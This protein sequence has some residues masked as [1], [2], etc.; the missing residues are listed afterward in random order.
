MLPA[1]PHYAATIT[2]G[3]GVNADQRLFD[4][5]TGLDL[6]TARPLGLRLV[7][8]FSQL[9]MNLLM[10]YTGRVVNGV[11]GFLVTA[12]TLTGMIIWWPGIA[13]WRDSLTVRWDTNL[14]RLNW[15]LHSAIGFWTSAIVL[16]W[17]VTGAYLVFPRPFNFII[18]SLGGRAISLGQIPHSIHVGDFGGWPVKAFGSRLAWCPPRFSSPASSC[19]GSAWCSRSFECKSAARRQRRRIFPS[20]S[21]SSKPTAS[22]NPKLRAQLSAPDR[23]LTVHL[24]RHA[25]CY[26]AGSSGVVVSEGLSAFSLASDSSTRFLKSPWSLCESPLYIDTTLISHLAPIGSKRPDFCPG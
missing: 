14:K 23:C 22:A 15:S 5:Y 26:L 20:P 7:S 16:M 11:G 18:D 6:G 8:F 24:R 19:G 17:A 4:P 21:R 9:H 1:D 13:R 2:L 25:R 3:L 10:D 12:L